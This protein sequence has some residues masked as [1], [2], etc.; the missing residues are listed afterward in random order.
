MLQLLLCVMLQPIFLSIAQQYY[1][2]LSLRAAV[3][4][5][6]GEVRQEIELD[7]DDLAG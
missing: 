3:M 1:R 2:G 6:W 4:Q 5:H 7:V